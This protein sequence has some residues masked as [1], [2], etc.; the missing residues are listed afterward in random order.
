MKYLFIFYFLGLAI[1]FEGYSRVNFVKGRKHVQPIANSPAD[2]DKYPVPVPL[3]TNN[4]SQMDIKSSKNISPSSSPPAAP[5]TEHY[6][7]KISSNEIEFS[8]SP[9]LLYKDNLMERCI[10]S[11]RR[12][13]SIKDHGQ[14]SLSS[15]QKIL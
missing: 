7:M 13:M 10:S 1:R 9:P 8:D 4:N 2:D 11:S 12:H 3:L 6:A 15:S 14:E 5:P